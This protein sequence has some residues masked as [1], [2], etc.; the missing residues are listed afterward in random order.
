MNAFGPGTDE[1]VRTLGRALPQT[2][3]HARGS[4][5]YQAAT[6][7]DNASF[8]QHPAVVVR[9]VT[10]G[11]AAAAVAV[12]RQAGRRVVAQATGHGSG[13]P[14]DEDVL[15]VDT[16]GLGEVAVDPGAA[17]ARVGAGATWDAV[18]EGAEAHGLLGLSGT[19]PTV[20]VSGYTFAGGVG[21]LTRPY[22]LASA[23]LRAV[24][25]VDGEGTVRRAADDAP[26]PID[27]DALWAFRGGAPVGLATVLDIDLHR[28]GDLWAGSLLWPGSDLTELAAAWATALASAPATLTSAFSLLLI[29]PAGPFPQELLG[30]AAVHLSYAT[31]GGE[32]DLTGMRETLRSVAAPVA[33]TTAA[34]DARTL[35]LI[36]L[37][38][39]AGIPARGDGWWLHA[40]AAD[41][42][43]PLFGAA[44]IGQPGGLNMIEIRHV[45]ADAPAPDGA[46]TRAPGAFLAHAVGAGPSGADRARIDAVLA[47]VQDT[48]SPVFTGRSA[49]SFREGQ[50]DPATPWPAGEH[51][52]LTATAAALDPDGVLLFQ[53]G[54]PRLPRPPRRHPADYPADVPLTARPLCQAR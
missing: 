38:P 43:V 48:A 17:R 36:H 39:P 29:P 42:V 14:L 50:P 51:E 19:S 21:W 24:E 25:Y 12:A 47:G 27:R 37:D 20:G 44:R 7:P 5:G 3:V 30:S 8:R 49:P 23:S 26:D 11:Q 10:A 34:A 33:D 18:Q 16:S 15:L 9:P 53:R 40:D 45:A 6:I 54:L 41:L 35:A 13:M 22:G 31:I 46:L 32:A 2:L 52:R 28:R 1:F 4:A